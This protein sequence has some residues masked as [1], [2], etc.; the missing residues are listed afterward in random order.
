MVGQQFFSLDKN[1]QIYGHSW[2]LNMAEIQCI[3][4]H[5]AFRATY[6]LTKV[7]WFGM[8]GLDCPGRV[9][10]QKHNIFLDLMPCIFYAK[11]LNAVR[12]Q[13]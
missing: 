11:I 6:H 7:P 4:E 12:T 2:S 13:L 9:G 5:T 1:G 10:F 3:F 8:S